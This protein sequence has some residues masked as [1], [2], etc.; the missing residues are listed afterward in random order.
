MENRTFQQV[1][2][3]LHLHVMPSYIYPER[4]QDVFIE[5]VKAFKYP[6][7]ETLSARALFS[8]AAPH[9]YPAF[10]AV[11]SWMVDMCKDFDAIANHYANQG[12][13]VDEEDRSEDANILFFDYSVA[14]YSAFLNGANTFD[15]YYQKLLGLL[16]DLKAKYIE[17]AKKVSEVNSRLQEQLNELKSKPDLKQKYLEERARMEKDMTKF[18][19][20]NNEMRK[21]IAKYTESIA[22]TERELKYLE[23]QCATVKQEHME[24]Q[25]VLKS[26]NT[27]LEEIGRL[28]DEQTALEKECANSQSLA[29]KL[30]KEQSTLENELSKQIAKVIWRQSFVFICHFTQKFYYHYLYFD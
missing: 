8:V 20:Y 26:H 30:A 6:R 11:L 23:A 9:S 13:D 18:E 5:I 27:S 29:Q 2:K 3:F 7:T 16:D 22:K 15:E 28:N 24:M 10:L 12:E 25:Q 19:E 14:T 1:F 17:N 21:R 4:F